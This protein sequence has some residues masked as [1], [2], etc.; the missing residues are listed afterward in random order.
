MDEGA[1]AVLIP[2]VS[3]KPRDEDDNQ[4]HA[5]V[6]VNLTTPPT[7][8]GNSPEIP[9][10]PTTQG[11]RQNPLQSGDPK[12][13]SQRRRRERDLEL[14]EILP[15]NGHLS[16]YEIQRQIGS[17]RFSTVFRAKS[18]KDNGRLVAIKKI[19]VRHLW[20]AAALLSLVHLVLNDC[21]NSLSSCVDL[22][23]H[24]LHD[25]PGRLG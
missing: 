19:Q 23:H 8:N 1:E 3:V 5:D 16:H 17:G 9:T 20:A 25:G 11:N 7:A 15:S 13:Q 10:V 2:R 21:I 12:S 24:G 4:V 22:R 14:E 18:V 6:E